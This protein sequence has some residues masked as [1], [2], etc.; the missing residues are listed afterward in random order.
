MRK[1][2]PV[3]AIRTFGG[4]DIYLKI[5]LISK[6]SG[7]EWLSL[8]SGR[9]DFGKEQRT[10]LPG[11]WV[12]PRAFLD[13]MKK[14][15]SY[16][17]FASLCH[18]CMSIVFFDSTALSNTNPA[19]ITMHLNYRR[20]RNIPEGSLRHSKHGESLKSRIFLLAEHR[21]LFA[22]F[23]FC[24]VVGLLWNNAFILF[25]FSLAEVSLI[26]EF[27]SEPCSEQSVIC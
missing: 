7:A 14:R 9:S 17:W 18:S 3:Q 1:D 13:V 23:S 5:F 15:K 4:V 20:R 25:T 22:L 12:G 27:P 24:S 8:G 19:A 21:H 10:H 16:C 11:D 6:L 26:T 2:F